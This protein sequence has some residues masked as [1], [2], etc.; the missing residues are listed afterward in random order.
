[1]DDPNPYQAP[2]EPG[3]PPPSATS[4]IK[5]IFFWTVAILGLPLALAAAGSSICFGVVGI[6]TIGDPISAML[7]FV[8]IVL[9]AVVVLLFWGWR[10][11]IK[12][13]NK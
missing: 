9:A 13:L 8:A 10:Q 12:R 7:I 5:R 4:P 11:S 2:Q 1:M 6:I 3:R